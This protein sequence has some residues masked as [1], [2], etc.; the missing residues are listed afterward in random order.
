VAQDVVV[1]ESLSEALV[2]DGAALVEKLD[3]AGWRPS[4]ALWFYFTDANAWRLLLASPEV[5]TKGPREAYTAIQRALAE[6]DP[7]QRE[8]ALEDIGVMPIDHPIVGLLGV[9][10][11]TGPGIGRMRF[12]KNVINGQF[13][14]DALIYRLV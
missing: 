13:I 8:L 1:K 12:S 3:E 9:M 10:V 14:D 5:T 11:R 4:A 6:L 7:T 2:R